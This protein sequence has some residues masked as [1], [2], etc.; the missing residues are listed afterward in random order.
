MAP[1]TPIAPEPAWA[2]WVIA[3]LLVTAAAILLGME[4]E[5]RRQERWQN[6]RYYPAR[7]RR[8]APRARR[9]RIHYRR[10]GAVIRFPRRWNPWA[11]WV[12]W[13]RWKTLKGLGKRKDRVTAF[14]PHREVR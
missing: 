6:I 14:N 9:R 4:L 2:G 1:M 5:A 7:H 13:P 8:P 11:R 3:L 12:W 10:E